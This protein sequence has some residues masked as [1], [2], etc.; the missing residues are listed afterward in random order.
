MAADIDAEGESG[1]HL[2]S[3]Y[4]VVLETVVDLWLVRPGRGRVDLVDSDEALFGVD[5]VAMCRP[6]IFVVFL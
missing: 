4:I 1:G 3:F 5:F 2:V 6:R